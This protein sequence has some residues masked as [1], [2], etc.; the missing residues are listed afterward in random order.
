MDQSRVEGKGDVGETLVFLLLSPSCHW[1]PLGEEGL[2]RLGGQG[3]DD[4]DGGGDH[5]DG[6]DDHDDN[7]LCICIE[8]SSIF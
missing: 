2:Q 7:A 6:G 1:V 5:D 4:D 8:M 3:E